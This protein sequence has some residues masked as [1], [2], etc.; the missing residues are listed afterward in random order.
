MEKGS[1]EKPTGAIFA[2][3]LTKLGRHPS[4]FAI[5]D[6]LTEHLPPDRDPDTWAGLMI[7]CL[8]G[9]ALQRGTKATI[10]EL[11]AACLEYPGIKQCGWSPAHFLASVNRT[12]T[13]LRKPDRTDGRPTLANIEKANADFMA[14]HS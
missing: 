7:G 11:A 5:L 13:R 12:V 2:R 8:D 10:D 9:M 6:L 14:G 4:R 3:L 1:G